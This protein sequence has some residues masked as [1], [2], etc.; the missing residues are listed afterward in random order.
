MART[1][2]Y[3]YASRAGVVEVP[4]RVAKQAAKARTT[5]A[6]NAEVFA[7]VFKSELRYDHARGRWL[8]WEGHRWRPDDDAAVYRLALEVIRLRHK[9][10]VDGYG[11]MSDEERGKLLQHA[12]MSEARNRLEAMLALARTMNPLSDSGRGWDETAGLLGVPNGVVDLRTGRLRKG[13]PG[14][15]ITM[16]TAVAYDSKAT[17]PRFERF[18]S[19]VLEDAEEV[20]P[21]LQ[22]LIGYSLTAEA[23]LHL[24]VFLMG[25]GGNGKSTLIRAVQRA[26][27]DY[28]RVISSKAFDAEARGAHTTEVA[29]L[30][31]ARFAYCEE[32][33][34]TRLNAER[35][36]DVSGGGAKRARRMRTDTFQ[37]EQTWQLF[38]STNDLPRSD[39][40]SWGWWRRVHAVDFPRQFVGQDADP[41]LDEA[42][43][44]EAAGII[45]W[46]VRGAVAWYRD[47]LGDPPE[48]VAEKT[49]QYREDVDPL[50]PLFEAAALVKA[51]DEVTPFEELYAAYQSW[52]NG[53][54]LGLVGRMTE[55]RFGKALRGRFPQKRV[56]IDG[57][58]VRAYVGVRAGVTPVTPELDVAA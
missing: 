41:G 17:C 44:D 3:V 5:D 56:R 8:I 46:V 47:G 22:R 16:Q 49:A 20:A 19:E 26:L 57:R 43:A 25:Q 9:V 32:L 52:C 48:A 1:R 54:S 39:D 27:G 37:F 13:R 31:G 36:K 21:W 29:D 42:L 10:A 35:L 38:F 40:N 14:D 58:Q 28:A 4:A 15:R 33:G 30:A 53:R 6:G 55:D 51:P 11:G 12:W 18:L 45:A 34:S 2:S 50:E 7:E 24:L 23:T